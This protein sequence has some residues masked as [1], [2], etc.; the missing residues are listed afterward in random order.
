MSNSQFTTFVLAWI[1]LAILMFPFVLRTKAP[2]GR[3]TTS[4]WGPLIPNSL[5]WILMEAPSLLVFAYF[6]LTGTHRFD[7]VPLIF[8]GFWMFHYI[9][10]TFVF[11]LRIR[12]RGKKMPVS[13]VLMACCFNLVNGFINGYYIGTL[14]TKY[15]IHWLTNPF[16]IAGAI[17][18]I[19]GLAINLQSDNIL[20]HLRKP[21]ES[22]YM[23]PRGGLFDLISCPNHF[24]EILEWCGFALMTLSLSGLAFAIWTFVNLIPRAIHHHRWYKATFPDYPK[25]RKAIVPFLI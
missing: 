17:I 23:I 5:G 16:F 19:I 4:S 21:G 7:L 3:H 10:R 6:F 24:S 20:I 1:G 12:T 18:C 2:Y 8:F 13:I 25:E 22:G 11:P 14:S 15:D 9:N